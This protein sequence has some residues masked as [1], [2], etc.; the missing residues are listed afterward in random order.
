MSCTV[1]FS[2]KRWLS[3]RRFVNVKFYSAKVDK[4]CEDVLV[5]AAMFLVTA[6]AKATQ[7][8]W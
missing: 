4:M 8:T 2:W 6:L 5:R 1:M 7:S 3:A